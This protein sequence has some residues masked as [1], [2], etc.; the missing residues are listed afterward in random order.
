M[1][2]LSSRSTHASASSRFTTLWE[3]PRLTSP[4]LANSSSRQARPGS[5]SSARTTRVARG[6]KSERSGRVEGRTFRFPSFSIS[7]FSKA[8]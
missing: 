5:T 8:R 6:A 2:W 4:A 1:R 3:C 7:T